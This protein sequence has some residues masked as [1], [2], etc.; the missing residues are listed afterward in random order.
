MLATRLLGR[1]VKWIQDRRENLHVRRPRPRGPGHGDHG[2]RRRRARS[3]ARRSTSSRARARSP[4]RVAARPCSRPM[5]FPG[6]YRIPAFA[7]SAQTVHTNTAGRGS[8]RGPVDVRDGGAR[9]DD[10][11]PRG[12]ARHRSAR[13][14][15]TQ[16]DP[17]AT[18]CRTRCRA[19][20]VYDQMTAAANLE[21]AAEMIGYDELREQQRAWRAEGRLVGIGISLFAEP[22]AMAFGWMTTDGADRAHRPERAR[23][24]SSR[25]RRATVRASRR[26]SRR[27]SP[28]SSASTSRTSACCRATPTATPLGPAPAGAGAR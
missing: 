16:R 27:S 24:T 17:R 15:A 18:T 9:A 23:P 22:T 2:R 28:T 1:P 5:L 13:A 25:A 26:R 6:P 7:A 11:L 3:S 14:A 8:Y 10:G 12:A 21:Q 4:R 19:A 20:C